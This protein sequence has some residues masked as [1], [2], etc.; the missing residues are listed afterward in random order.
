MK[1]MHSGEPENMTLQ[2]E[3]YPSKYVLDTL[4][5]VLANVTLL[6]NNDFADKIKMR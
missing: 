3:L 4:I 2:V 1:D 5:S 6:E